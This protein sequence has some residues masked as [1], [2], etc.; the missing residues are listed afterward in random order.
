MAYASL[1]S[2][3]QT[4]EQILHH[5]DDQC[6][7]LHQQE[8]QIGRSL[9]EKVRFFLSFLEDHSQKNSET[10]RCLE[11]RIR[12]AAYEAED[13]IESQI[14]ISDQILSDSEDVIESQIDTSDQIVS[15]SE[16]IIESQI[17]TSDQILSDSEDVIESQID[18]SDQIVSDS[19]DLIESQIL[20]DSEDIIESQ[21]DI[22]DQIL[23]DSVDVIES[24]IDT[25]D[26]IILSDSED[27]IEFQIDISDDLIVSDFEDIIE[28]QIDISDLIV[29]DF[30]DIIESQILSDSEDIIESQIDISD[31]IVSDS[32]NHCERC[33][34]F[35]R[36]NLAKKYENLQ[37]VIQEHD[38]ISE[39]VVN[40]MDRNDVEIL[41]PRNPFPTG[42]SKSGSSN[43]SDMVGF[44]DDLMQIKDRLT[45][46][47][48]KLEIV[49]I[50]GMGGIGKTTFARNVY[51]DPLI[52]YHFDTRAWTTISQEYNVK[53]MLT[54]LL[55]STKYESNIENLDEQIYKCLKGKR[56]L[57]VL[58]DMWDTKAW[59][60]VQL[61]FPD[62]SNGSRII[63]TTRLADVAVYAGSSSAIHH[64]SCLNPEKSWNLLHQTVFGEECCPCELKEIGKE[65]AKNCKGLPL[66]LVVI[67]GPLYKGKMTLDY[68]MYVKENVNSAVIGTDD[69]FMEI[70]FIH[71]LMRDLCVRKAQEENFLHL[72]DRLVKNF[73]EVTYNQRRVSIHS[74][75]YGHHLEDTYG[76][77]VRSLLYYSKGTYFPT[78]FQLLR[79]LNALR[80]RFSEFPVE[81]VE[82]FNLRYI[83]LNCIG[84]CELPASISKLCNLQTL[85]IYSLGTVKLPSDIWKMP[86]LRHIWTW[87]CFLAYPSA[88]GNGEK[89]AV[90]ENLQT[91]KGVIDFKFTKK[92]LQMMPNLK[93]LKIGLSSFCIDKFIHLHQLEDLNCSFSG[94]PG[95]HLVENFHLPPTLKRLTLKNCR[96]SWKS[97]AIIG[98][99]PNLEVLN[100]QYFNI[101]G[102][103]WEPTEGKFLQLKVLLLDGTDLEHFKADETNFPILQHLTFIDCRKLLEIPSAIGDIP[104]LQ[105]IKLFGCSASAVNSVKLIPE[106]QRDL[107]NDNLQIIIQDI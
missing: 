94:Y 25:S 78:S 69:Q 64:L 44:D 24:Q 17:D 30:E 59:D 77:Q 101:D 74:G 26:Q 92:V 8:E 1:L 40:M 90:L 58:D 41:P 79:V 106:E 19:E 4:L 100:L 97:M 43:N 45:G 37:K 96:V 62:D 10:I 56:Y 55:D 72:Y 66:A 89:I 93:K 105:V 80:I 7:V 99:L 21:I 49:S 103:V 87:R 42:S 98:S 95:S 38:S 9:L 83:V 46:S 2:L 27:I 104:T 47:P 48:S 39:H 28:F 68:W 51:E 53:K 63:L 52:E 50:V 91:L 73:P 16:D 6:Q 54:D 65:I 12:V 34:E 11:G 60:E 31:Q 29:S 76:S 36:H 61:L 32:R 70:L 67:G 13:I 35:S 23:S 102:S 75:I 57:I 107:G 20:S 86:R 84:T 71:D 14:D 5:P 81:I 15:D 18:T 88:A 3:T 33:V 82:L 85:I 22:S